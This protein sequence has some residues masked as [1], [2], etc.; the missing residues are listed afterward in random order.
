KDWVADTAAVALVLGLVWW[1]RRAAN[2]R[3]PAGEAIPR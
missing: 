2:E 3:G 1:R